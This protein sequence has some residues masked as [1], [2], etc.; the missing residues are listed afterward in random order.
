MRTSLVAAAV[1]I[2]VMLS[3]AP[4][5]AFACSPD[6]VPTG[7]D[8]DY[9]FVNWYVFLVWGVILCWFTFTDLNAS[10]DSGITTDAWI[11]M[12]LHI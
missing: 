7:W 5:A 3:F 6:F 10:C 4:V 12:L 8:C 11:P 9:G 1:T 2:A